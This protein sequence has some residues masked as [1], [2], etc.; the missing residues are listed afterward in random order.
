M[1]VN[2]HFVFQKKE[3]FGFE[4]IVFS[5]SEYDD[6][7]YW[8]HRPVEISEVLWNLRENQLSELPKDFEF[9]YSSEEHCGVYLGDACYGCCMISDILEYDWSVYN[10]ETMSDRDSIAIVKFISLLNNLKKIHGEVRMVYGI[11]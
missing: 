5:E 9:D 8:Y 4:D 3:K 7:V 2:I 11:N 10:L 1:G 6:C